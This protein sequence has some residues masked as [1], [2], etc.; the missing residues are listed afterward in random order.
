MPKRIQR[1]R[2]AGWRMP[3]DAVY[4]GRPTK[5]GN[6]YRWTDYR[7]T[8]QND[9]G[10]PCYVPESDRRRFAVSDFESEVLYG[11]GRRPS[12]PSDEEIRA[13]L[14]GKDLVCWCP[15]EDEHGNPVRCHADTLL[16]IANAVPSDLPSAA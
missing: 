4:V 16:Q 11:V 14:A 6:P 9:D 10:E 7:K 15:L 8:F 3:K 12:Y 5:W 13:E 1:K 2:T